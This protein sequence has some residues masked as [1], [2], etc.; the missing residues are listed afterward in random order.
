[1]GLASVKSCRILFILGYVSNF[2]KNYFT[3]GRMEGW[4]SGF[5]SF[6]PSIL[7]TTKRV[8]Q[9]LKHAHF[10]HVFHT[11]RAPTGFF[12][13][14]PMNMY[15]QVILFLLLLTLLAGS[16]YWI[17][18]HFSPPSSHQAT[19]PVTPSQQGGGGPAA[20]VKPPVSQG[21]SK[22]DETIRALQERLKANPDDFQAYPQLASAY[23]QKVREVSDPTYY[24]KTEAL[25]RKAI[26][27]QPNNVEVMS[28]TGSLCLARHQFRDALAWGERAK[29]LAPSSPYVYG[30][31]TDAHIELGEYEQAVS[32]LQ[33]MVNLRPD[34]SS[35]SR[36]SYL[37]ELHGDVEGAVEA[38]NMAINAG[39]AGTEA[40]AWCIVQL[41]H[42]HFNSGV[43]DLAEAEYQR[44]R[45]ELP[46][47]VHALAGR[48]RIHAVRTSYPE[49]ISLY[50]QVV[51]TMPIPE[52]VI[53]LGEVYQVS[54][55]R[56]KADQQY[57]LVRAMSAIYQ[58]NGVDTDLEM[59]RF[60]A[61][62]HQNL[63]EALHRARQAFEARPSIYAVDVLAWTLYQAGEYKEAYEVV[64]QALRLGTK[65]A[66]LHFHA[67]MIGKQLGKQKEARD[68]LEQALAINPYF[69]L[70]YA[71]EAA[72]ALKELRNGGAST[73]ALKTKI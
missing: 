45:I 2:P 28:L 11:S 66:L 57:A 60:D 55:E 54:G 53:A 1:M 50:T 21:R 47:Y 6:H 63:P 48:A 46:N 22:L 36:I 73:A 37:R 17:W 29:A 10:K 30:V 24:T 26:S 40:R 72:R 62:H 64:R 69:S 3:L 44:A 8:K 39:K 4:K 14:S 68:Y 41:G 27:L 12:R 49:A 34:L 33:Q 70:L 5:P 13:T 25:L 32:S 42:L 43:L 9:F 52:Y 51:D 23:L 58:D 71:E 7:P 38:M 35:Y 20:P 31:L 16:G 65:D 56:V 19:S 67:G 61:D 18:H 59:A 15:K